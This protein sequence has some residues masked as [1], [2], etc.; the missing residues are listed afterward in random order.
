[1]LEA[2][3]RDSGRHSPL[4]GFALDGYPV[5]GPWGFAN[6][7][8][9]GGLRRMRSSYR[10]RAIAERTAWADGTP[11]TAGQSGPPVSADYPLGTFAEDY[12]FV[13]GSGDLDQF[14]GRFAVTPEYPQGT[15]AYFLASDSA[16]RLAFPYLLASEFCGAVPR[17]AELRRTLGVRRRVAL[18]AGALDAGQPSVLDFS[19]ADRRGDRLRVLESVHEKPL[20]VMVVSDDLAEFDHIHPELQSSGDWEVGYTFRHAG[21]YRIYAEFTAPGEDTRT[22]FFD[23]TVDGPPRR[24]VPLVETV[25]R[26]AATPAMAATL[27]TDGPIVAGRDV[28]L[29]LLLRKPGTADAVEGL[30]PYLGA[31]AHFAIAAQGLRTFLHAHPLA[32][33]EAPMPPDCTMHSHGAVV[34]PPPS[35]VRTVV[36]FATPGLYK[37]W[38]QFQVSGEVEVVPIVFRVR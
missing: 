14:N 2:M 1:L 5:Y 15:Y 3:L 23:V 26:R 38:A 28:E 13:A 8:G 7:D 12:E 4:L 27:Q 34:G 18:S 11:L 24:T 36:R 16:A 20:H 25:W 37:L 30:E 6:A 19:I 32:D 21:R 17:P 29:R 31:W 33:G 22:E 35:E 10:K 9:S